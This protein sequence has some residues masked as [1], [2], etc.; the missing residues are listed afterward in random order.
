MK[1]LSI[2]TLLFTFFICKGLVFAQSA[3][4]QIIHN[5][6]DPA[7]DTVDVYY[8]SNGVFELVEDSVAFRTATPYASVPVAGTDDTVA[9]VSQG[10]AYPDDTI[11]TASADFADGD[12]TAIFMNGVVGAEGDTALGLYTTMGEIDDMDETNASV[13]IFHGVTDAPAVD[14]IAESANGADTLAQDI[15]YGNFTDYLSI[16]PANYLLKVEAADNSELVGAYDMEA[17]SNTQ[18]IVFASGFMSPD[19]IS[20]DNDSPAFG[21]YFVD[22]AGNVSALPETPD[23]GMV[24]TEDQNTAVS[25]CVD[26]ES[27]IIKFDSSQTVGMNY[28]YVITDESG[29]VILG[30]P[31]ADSADFNDSVGVSQV[32][33]LSYIGDMPMVSVGDSVQKLMNDST[34]LSS[35]SITVYRDTVDGGTVMSSGADTVMLNANATP[36]YVYFSSSNMG[37]SYSPDAGYTYVVTDTADEE[38]LFY[39]SADSVDFAGI[40]EDTTHVHG[41]SHSGDLSADS[42]MN[43][44]AENCFDQSDN[45]VTV[46]QSS[47]PYGGTVTTEGGAAD[48]SV[49]MDGTADVIFFDSSDVAP[50]YSYMYL[51]TDEAGEVILDL[52]EADS[53]DFNDSTGVFKVWGLSYEGDLSAVSAGDSV[54]TIMGDTTDLSTPLTVYTDTVAGDSVMTESG[55]TSVVL[56]S[57]TVVRFNTTSMGT[58]YSPDANYGYVVTDTANE[59]ILMVSSVADTIDFANLDSITHVHGISYSGELMGTDSLMNLSAANCFSLS[60]NHVE[61]TKDIVLSVDAPEATDDEVAVYP[62][63][64]SEY[65]TVELPEAAQAKAVITSMSGNNVVSTTLNTASSKVDVSGLAEGYYVLKVQTEGDVYIEKLLVK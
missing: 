30:L 26:N 12:T 52:P 31:E 18:G 41:I 49:C 28:A 48:T 38:I 42:L 54:K 3:E 11:K 5:A 35:N 56:E 63:P 50:D 24:H 13:K 60:D 53:A 46:I 19:S 8:G 32:W 44:S 45:Y 43:L 37:T 15:S 25:I 10:G 27:D 57:T 59:E 22:T 51:I 23:A 21:L 65:V 4:V 64:A 40:T 34:D 61:V 47:Q 2:L 33:G 62:N 20:P 7:V 14:V 29:D 36:A 39:S 1:R 55:D 6:A 17:V 9:I 16:A 58:T